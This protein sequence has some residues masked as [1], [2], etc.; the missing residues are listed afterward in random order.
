[1]TLD[2][3]LEAFTDHLRAKRSVHTVRAY[4]T[5]LHQLF[6]DLKSVDELNP[7]VVKKWLRDYAPEPRTRSRKLSALKTFCAFVH[8]Y[9]GVQIT[10]VES[11]DAPYRRRTLPKSL[12]E[13]ETLAVLDHERLGASPHRDQA[14]IELLYGCGVRA[15]ELVGV[16]LN[17]IDFQA[18]AITVLGKGAKERLVFFGRTC[19][20]AIQEYVASERVKPVSGQALFTN[21][22]GGRLSTRSVQKIVHR[23]MTESGSAFQATP[24]TFRHSFATHMLDHGADLKS[25][26]QLLGHESLTTTQIYTHVSVERLRDA[27]DSAHPKSKG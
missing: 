1:M 4:H 3:Y 20:F 12:P 16:D 19:A 10:A 15:A 13:S 11:V 17:R 26:Q 18:G 7:A 21:N 24:H 6:G 22:R 25:V 9:F 8:E 23:L 27:V 2:E 14:L 5:D